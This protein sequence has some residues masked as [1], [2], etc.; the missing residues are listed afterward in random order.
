MKSNKTKVHTRYHLKDGG[1]VPGVTTVL[2][3]LNKPALVP[4]ANKLGFAQIDVK[5]YVDDK[6][7]IGTGGHALVTD[8]LI[9]KETDLSDYSPNQVDKMDNCA[10]SFWEWEKHNHIEEVGFVELP[11]VSEKWKFGGTED[12]YARIGDEWNLI[13]LKTGSGIYREHRYQVAALA[14]LLQEHN[15]TVDRIRVLNIPRTEDERFVEEVLTW[16]QVEYGWDIF[17]HCL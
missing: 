16:R 12:I 14:K 9:G 15:Y 10:L 17:Y 1:L 3:I 5:K 4:W 7:W 2:G 8:K 13:D 6:A 11:L